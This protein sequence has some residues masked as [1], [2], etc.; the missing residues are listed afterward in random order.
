M[1]SRK[2]TQEEAEEMR[3]VATPVPGAS[4]SGPRFTA[5]KIT[6]EDAENL[7]KIYQQTPKPTPP[8]PIM[9]DTSTPLERA[10]QRLSESATQRFQKA[11]D[12]VMQ[13][14]EF[15]EGLSDAF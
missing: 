14:G 4:N 9:P 8:R 10:G 2:L 3:A 1:Q 13:R 6:Q 15:A 11:S 7:K 12:I 5:T